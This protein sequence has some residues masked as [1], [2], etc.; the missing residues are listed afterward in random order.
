MSNHPNMSYCAVENT[1]SALHQVVD[2]MTD[3]GEFDSIEEWVES[4]NE[5]ERD[6]LPVL[7]VHCR[8]IVNLFEAVGGT[9]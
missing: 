7:L 1:A 4:L 3:S 6:A 8:T 9:I 5:Y 2:M